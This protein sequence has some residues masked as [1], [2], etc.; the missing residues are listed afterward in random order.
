MNDLIIRNLCKSY[1][2]RAVLHHFNLVLPR[3]SVLGLMGESGCGK[4][5]L[6]RILLGL[7][8]A[9]SGSI[10]GLPPRISAVF[11]EDR[12]C[13]E[14]S[15]VTNVAIAAPRYTPRAAILECLSALGL[16]E[17]LD[18]PVCQLSGGM[19][20][21]V[22]IARALLAEGELLLLDEP[23]KGLDEETRRTV[24]AVVRRYMSGRTVLLVTHDPA[25]ISDMQATLVF[26]QHA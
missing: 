16:G 21:R 4:T 6:L 14:F 5:T 7:E 10:I 9:D 22:A 8:R 1:D 24:I 26:M 15:P 18:R 20:R 3:G 12:L 11:Q 2:G 19:R 23:F 17:A 13:S 25:D